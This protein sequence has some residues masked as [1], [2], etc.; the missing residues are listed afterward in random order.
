MK[1]FP[2]IVELNDLHSRCDWAL[3]IV[4]CL[5]LFPNSSS[6]EMPAWWPGSGEKEMSAKTPAE[7]TAASA[8]N[9]SSAAQ[10]PVASSDPMVDSPLFDIGWPKIELPKINWKP[11][12]GNQQPGDAVAKKDNPVSGALDK[13]ANATKGAADGVRNVWGSAIDKLTPGGTAKRNHQMAS[14]EEPGF[15]ARMFGPQPEPQ[16]SQTVTE[17]LAQDRPGTTRR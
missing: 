17:F 8:S 12:W 5:A 16:G 1:R 6:A 9:A 13:V 15:W 14:K 3:P 2:W 7:G 11:S 4:L 10:S